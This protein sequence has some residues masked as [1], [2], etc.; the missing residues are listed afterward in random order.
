MTSRNAKGLK[1]LGRKRLYAN[2]TERQRACRERAQ[3]SA[4]Q[5]TPALPRKSRKVSR[6]K[7]LAGLEDGIRDLL[8]EYAEWREQLPESLADTAQ[9]EALNATME[10]LTEAADLLAGINPPRGFGRD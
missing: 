9:A 3:L 7:R 8:A 5:R 4:P 6:P 10:A 2:A 1:T